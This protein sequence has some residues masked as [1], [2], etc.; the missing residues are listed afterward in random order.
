MEVE[1]APKIGL[2][3]GAP[4]SSGLSTGGAYSPTKLQVEYIEEV[5][6][7]PMGRKVNKY[8]KGAFLGKV[9]LTNKI[10]KLGRIC[11]ML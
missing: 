11:K 4:T 10:H 7:D 2:G 8:V 5:I 1:T 3:L 9:F 6:E